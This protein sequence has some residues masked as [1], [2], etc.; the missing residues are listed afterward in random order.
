MVARFGTD[1]IA[2][3]P[4][5]VLWQ[6]GTNSVL[7]DD[8]LEPHSVVLQ[9]GIAQL[10]EA[11]ADVVL[12]DLQFA[13]RV[14]A[15][16]ETEGMED[17][18][19]LAAKVASV[20]LF[21]RFAIMRNWHDV[22]HMAFEVFTVPRPAAYERLELRLPR[23]AARRRRSARQV[24]A[25]LRRQQC[26]RRAKRVSRLSASSAV[27]TSSTMSSGCSSPTDR[28]TSPS[29]MPSSAR[30]VRREPLMRRRRRVGIRLLASPRLLLIR[31]A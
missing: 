24:R 13:P 6:V 26:V 28:R 7:R 15:K 14:L 11:G 17:Q 16:P 9:D 31:S 1:V 19:A 29:V 20:D 30:C 8:P 4:D 25:R 10:K 21:D 12:I 3:N 27:S 18:I 5:L 22:Q 23:Q 2:V